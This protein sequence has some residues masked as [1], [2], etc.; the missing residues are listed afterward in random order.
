MPFDLKLTFTGMMLYVPEATRLQVLMPKTAE[1]MAA[2]VISS[3]GEECGASTTDTSVCVEP[4]A[5]RVTFD[6]AY[7]REGAQA[8]DDVLAHVSLRQ[9]RLEIPAVGG[10]YTRGI[11]SVVTVTSSPVRSDV[12]DGTADEVLMA[13]LVVSTGGAT[14]AD[15]GECWEYQ[16]DVRRMSH[17]VEW[18]IPDIDDDHLDLSMTD[19]A[20][21]AAQGSFPRLYPIDGKVELWVWHAPAYEL[22]PDAITP[23]EPVSGDQ[24]H[25]FAHLALLLDSRS[26]EM[27]LFRPNE[28]GEL[29]PGTRPRERDRGASVLS[30]TGAQAPVIP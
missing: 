19:L 20:G 23:E 8:L 24:A 7:V 29:P 2:P 27:P 21:M 18:T 22:P 11:P 12:L 13:R 1:T 5:A 6:T 10:S 17:Q 28:C 4:H 14:Y 25:H 26:L 15:P 3:T 30:C 9:K 16:G